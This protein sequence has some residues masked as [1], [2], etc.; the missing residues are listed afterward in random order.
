MR[1]TL[2]RIWWRSYW[3]TF[4]VLPILFKTFYVQVKT[5]RLK[6]YNTM[7]GI[8]LNNRNVKWR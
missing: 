2:T 7:V 8:Y 6:F 3:E 1:V 4:K 5:A